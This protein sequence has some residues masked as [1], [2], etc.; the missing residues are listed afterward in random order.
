M[1]MVETFCIGY[2][3]M[4]EV[5]NYRVHNHSKASSSMSN[6][7]NFSSASSSTSRFMPSI[8]ENVNE[9]IVTRDPENGQL[10]GANAREFDA[11]FP[12]DSWNHDTAFN[13]LKR[14]RD[15]FSNFS[16]SENQV[17][18]SPFSLELLLCLLCGLLLMYNDRGLIR[19]EKRG[20]ARMA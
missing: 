17:G 13:S 12:Q 14:N 11:L 1:L 5:E 19:M 3:I 2:G 6:H 8:P 9:S 10:G 15:M 4:G 20:E 16:G 18:T 7:I